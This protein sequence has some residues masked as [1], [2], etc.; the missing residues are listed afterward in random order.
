[1]ASA[2]QGRMAL[3]VFGVWIIVGK[4]NLGEKKSWELGRSW[5]GGKESTVKS[6]PRKL[7]GG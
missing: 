1:M 4:I 6:S 2:A 7:Q 3:R 5:P